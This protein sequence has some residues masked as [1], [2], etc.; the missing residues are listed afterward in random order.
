MAQFEH[1]LV[2]GKF[3]PPHR[4]H[5]F[6]IDAALAAADRLTILI[7]S[8]PDF[9]EMPSA[10]RAGWLT[11]LYPVAT[12]IVA[13]DGPPNDAPGPV[14]HRYI[15]ALLERRGEHP[16]VVFTSEDYGDAFAAALGVAHVAVDPARAHVPASGTMIRSDVHAHRHLLDARIY[17]Q[18]VERVV[19]LGAESTGKT[20]LTRRMADELD[21]AYVDEYGRTHYEQR[22]GV[23][24]LDDY[25]EI[26]ETHRR[27]ENEAILRANRWLFVD[28]NAVTT[29]FFSHYYNGDSLPRLRDLADECRARYRHHLVCAPDIAFEQDGWRDNEV[30][31]ARMHGMVRH[32]LAVR[33]IDHAVVHGA[34]DDR[35]A[36]VAAVLRGSPLGGGPQWSMGPRP[37]DGPTQPTP[38]ERR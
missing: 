7:W 32:D 15:A 13:D 4:G 9:T 2:V 8:N 17:G 28:T 18:F 20:T 26:A 3:A 12:V 6:L 21:T 37:V 31:R 29:M 38:T 23:L 16:D 10:V 5:Q 11:D 27:L 22:G 24:T 34:L 1:A 35:V 14:H 36:Q 19:F 25:V 30:W 33:R